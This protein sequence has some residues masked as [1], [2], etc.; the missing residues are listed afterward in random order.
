MEVECCR[1]EAGCVGVLDTERGFGLRTGCISSTHVFPCTVCG[2]VSTIQKNDDGKPI[3]V[4][5]Q[6]R[7][8]ED[9]YIE[10]DSLVYKAT[11]DCDMCGSIEHMQSITKKCP[12]CGKKLGS[13]AP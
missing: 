1:K 8:G 4:G 3:A 6:K 7:S 9:V 12:R 13:F 5:M 10:N 11:L 2:R